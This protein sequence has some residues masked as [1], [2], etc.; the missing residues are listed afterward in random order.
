MMATAP[1]SQRLKLLKEVAGTIVYDE[2]Q[3]ESYKILEETSMS[4]NRLYS[5][6][7]DQ[8]CNSHLVSLCQ[9]H[10]GYK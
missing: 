6:I 7:L 3:E 5:D 9:L 2:R 8:P 4:Y 10:S 1:D